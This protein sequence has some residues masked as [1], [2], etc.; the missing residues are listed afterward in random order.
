MRKFLRPCGGGAFILLGLSCVISCDDS[1]DFSNISTEMNIGGS[2]SAPIG[3]TDTLRL[4]RII[5]LTEELQVDEH[6][7]YALQSDGNISVQIAEVEKVHIQRLSPDLVE[8][9][10]PVSRPIRPTAFFV[11]RLVCWSDN[12]YRG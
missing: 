2:L 1:Y 3:E 10:L 4:S 8:V 7:A 9:P 6:G 5:D 11:G 12:E